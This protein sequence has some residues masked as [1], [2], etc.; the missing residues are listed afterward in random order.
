MMMSM[1]MLILSIYFMIIFMTNIWKMFILILNLFM[2]MFLMFKYNIY[3][4]Y[5]WNKIFYNLGMDKI[6]F[7]LSLLTIWI[8]ILSIM[9]MTL[10][11][12]NKKIFMNLML[13]MTLTLLL[14]FLSMNMMTFYIYFETSLIP[15]ILIIMGWGYQID[16]IQASMYMLFY[17]LVGSLPLLIMIMLIQQNNNTSMM[18][19]LWMKNIYNMNNLYLFLIMNMAFFIKMPMY[20][21]HLWLPKAHTEAPIS[22]SMVLAGIMLKLGSYGLYRSMMIFPNMMTSMNIYMIII[23]LIGSLISSLICMNQNDLKVIVAY[24]SIV[25]MSML[26]SSMFTLY[27]MSFKGSLLMMIAHGLCSSGM[28][29]L[30]NLNYERIQ[31]RSMFMN[32]NLINIL[33]SL[34]LWWF[35]LSIANFSAPPSMNLFSEMLMLN[36]LIQWNS[37]LI[38][39]IIFISFFSTC[40]SI[41]IYSFSQY[42]K[43]NIYFNFKSINCKEYLII[44]MHWL[45]LN[46]LFLNLNLFIYLIKIYL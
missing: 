27:K 37:L 3:F 39:I 21:L 30:V 18:N 35:L 40:Y 42:G 46:L 1:I 7:S 26:L 11:T 6:S 23:S 44:I 45:P 20:M 29:F 32:K 12:K 34:T 10:K 41:F 17:T 33:P 25:H 2:M 9:T 38:F 36:S 13:F 28:F 4:N 8:M 22:G 43:I 5:Y 16:R 14:S 15:I 31:S 19:I 24:S